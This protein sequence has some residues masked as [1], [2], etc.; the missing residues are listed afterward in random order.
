M[1]FTIS[2]SALY[3]RLFPRSSN[4]IEGKRHVNTIPV[5]FIWAEN[6]ARSTHPDTYLCTATTHSF[7]EKTYLLGQHEVAFISQDT[8]ARAPIGL[9]E[10]KQSPLMMHAEYNI[11]LPDHDYVKAAGHNLISDVYAGITIPSPVK[12]ILVI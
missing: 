8:K 12:A 9:T 7:Q 2:T 10:N 4:T 6:S 5:R 11:R 3:L 1:G